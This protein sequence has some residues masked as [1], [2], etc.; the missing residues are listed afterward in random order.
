[1]DFLRGTP[2][3]NDT[4][5]P[6]HIRAQQQPVLDNGSSAEGCGQG[7]GWHQG[8]KKGHYTF[9]MLQTSHFEKKKI[10][11]YSLLTNFAGKWIGFV[12]TLICL[13]FHL[14]SQSKQMS[15][16]LTFLTLIP[17]LRVMLW[18]A[19]QHR[20][21]RGLSCCPATLT[22]ATPEQIL[23]SFSP[24]LH[25]CKPGIE[26]ADG[27]SCCVCLEGAWPPPGGFSCCWQQGQD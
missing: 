1:M 25:S 15:K 16:C 2:G 19:R 10:Y 27:R 17:R 13:A 8:S 11:I 24:H 5:W 14:R 20:A 9:K 6:A 26:G 7:Q 21:G 18:Q 22:A 3:S 4:A 23:G 12:F